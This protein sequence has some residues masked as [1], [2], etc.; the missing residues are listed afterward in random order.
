MVKETTQT[1]TR[2]IGIQIIIDNNVWTTSYCLINYILRSNSDISVVPGKWCF[3]LQ[4][5]CMTYHGGI[6]S[7]SMLPK[8]LQ[9]KN[10][11]LGT[12][13]C[14]HEPTT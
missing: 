13:Y 1:Y 9:Q 6:M 7:D 10:T 14:I 11:A 12:L 3:I 8:V 5:T 2:I 4:R